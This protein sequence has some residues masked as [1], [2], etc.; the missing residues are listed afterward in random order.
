MAFSVAANGLVGLDG[1]IVRKPSVVF[2]TTVTV[3]E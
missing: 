3:A 2:G 1:Y